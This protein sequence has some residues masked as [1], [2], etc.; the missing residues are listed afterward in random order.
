MTPQSPAPVAGRPLTAEA[1]PIEP[2]GGCGETNPSRRCLGCLHDFVSRPASEQPV[3]AIGAGREEIE[4]AVLKAV[5]LG[6]E[7]GECEKEWEPDHGKEIARAATDRIL[8]ALSPA[9]PARLRPIP[10]HPDGKLGVPAS[11]ARTPMGEP[12]AWIERQNDGTRYG[13]PKRWPPSDRARSYAQEM[14]RTIE[15]LYAAASPARPEL[16]VWYGKMPESNGREN[17]T[18][19]LRRVNPTDKW[20]QGFCFARSEYPGRVL[21]EAD[22]VRW[23]IG[24]RAERPDILAY[25]ADAHSGYVEP[26]SPARTPMGGRVDG[27][28]GVTWPA[29]SADL[30]REEGLE[31]IDALVDMAR[32]GV[33]LMERLPEG[34][35]YSD[36]PTEIVTDLQNKLD[37]AKT[38]MGGEVE[39]LREALECVEDYDHT[40]RLAGVLRQAIDGAVRIDHL[41]PDQQSDIRAHITGLSDPE[42]DTYQA[43]EHGWTCFHCGATFKTTRGA[44]MH[45]GHNVTGRPKCHDPERL[46]EIYDGAEAAVAAASPA[47][48]DFEVRVARRDEA[49]N[50]II[51]ALA[52]PTPM[53]GEVEALREA[54]KR[55]EVARIVE[56]AIVRHGVEETALEGTLRDADAI[57]KA[58]AASSPSPAQG[59]SV[60]RDAMQRIAEVSGNRASRGFNETGRLDHINN[61]AND[62]LSA[63]PQPEAGE[64]VYR[65]L[66]GG[67]VIQRGDQMLCDDCETWEDVAGWPIGATYR[68]AVFV[69]IRRP[70]A[71][72]PSVQPVEGK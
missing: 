47:R 9:S 26:A 35:D 36:C 61:I 8:A 23:I 14:G 31:S 22:R 13:E 48:A 37:E 62:A 67:E 44:R 63:S 5:F 33:N 3:E 19:V 55:E 57:L 69:P 21:Y 58:L 49:R 71:A 25:D 27:H 29:A 72:P 28:G 11:P 17:W 70:V 20:D 7:H 50:A 4:A 40:G 18:A 38:P 68:S 32:V 54:A 51:A 60:L 45:F 64:A 66:E 53:G 43:P 2:C 65:A 46:V 56:L 42:E 34:Y 39:A 30:A 12:V 52:A 1:D 15:P 24:E 41:T 59:G 10:S 6:F 16:T